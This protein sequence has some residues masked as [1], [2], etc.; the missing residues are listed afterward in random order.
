MGVIFVIFV[1]CF[2]GVGGDAGVG[3]DSVVLPSWLSVGGRQIGEIKN[4]FKMQ[5]IIYIALNRIQKTI[6]SSHVHTIA[7]TNSHQLQKK[8][9]VAQH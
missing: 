7:R 2:L 4:I 8:N 9:D 1:V 3:Q 6:Q 5:Y